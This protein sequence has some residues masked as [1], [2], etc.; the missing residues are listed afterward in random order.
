MLTALKFTLGSEID[1]VICQRKAA[2]D[3]VIPY[4]Y[5]GYG[6]NTVYIPPRL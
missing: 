2:S 6:G 4:R 1:K 3:E 5:K